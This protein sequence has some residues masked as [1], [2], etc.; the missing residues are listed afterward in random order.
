[1]EPV[2]VSLSTPIADKSGVRSPVRSA[3]S[4]MA[5]HNLPPLDNILCRK[6]FL[7]FF[8]MSFGCSALNSFMVLQTLLPNTAAVSKLA[9]LAMQLADSAQTRQGTQS[10]RWLLGVK[11]VFRLG[12]QERGGNG[13]GQNCSRASGQP[14]QEKTEEDLGAM[15]YE[16]KRTKWQSKVNLGLAIRH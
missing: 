1:M 2:A 15:S 7:V 16:E 13:L 9:R 8:L 14:N 10:T 12:M 11:Q 6:C 3:W 5:L 4:F